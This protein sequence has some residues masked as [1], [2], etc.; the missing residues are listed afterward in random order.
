MSGLLRGVRSSSSFLQ[1]G[2]MGAGAIAKCHEVIASFEQGNQAAF[3]EFIGKITDFFGYPGEVFLYQPQSGERIGRVRVETGRNQDQL[4]RKISHER[5]NFARVE[6]SKFG[7]AIAVAKGEISDGIAHRIFTRVAGARIEWHLVTR[8]EQDTVIAVDEILSAVAV[9]HVEINDCDPL[10]T[11]TF[12]SVLGGNRD[13]SE[14]AKS[15]R[16]FTLGMV[17]GW[18]CRDKGVTVRSLKHEIDGANRTANGAIG[19]G[20]RTGGHMRIGIKLRPAR[21]RDG[22]LDPVEIGRRVG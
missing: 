12:Q 14:E 8:D 5:K 20:E 17:P 10:K 9:M 21:I 6:L 7:T 4:R 15:H 1:Y 18:A 16:R 2:H 19:S 3:A 22:G 13:I 11:V